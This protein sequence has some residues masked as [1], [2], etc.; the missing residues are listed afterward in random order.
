MFALL[1]LWVI[2]LSSSNAPPVETPPAQNPFSNLAAFA[3][4]LRI[5]GSQLGRAAQE[6]YNSM[7]TSMSRTASV[8]VWC[9]G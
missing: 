9:P 1:D 8:R 3:Q 6:E 7:A 5:S 2:D 4:Q